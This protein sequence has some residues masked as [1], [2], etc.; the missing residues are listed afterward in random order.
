MDK[1]LIITKGR[2]IMEPYNMNLYSFQK[3]SSICEGLD[4][5]TSLLDRPQ[6][7]ELKEEAIEGLTTEICEF[8]NRIDQFVS[9]FKKYQLP[10]AKNS[11]ITQ[12]NNSALTLAHIFL[13][14][15]KNLND[16]LTLSIQKVQI[17]VQ[18]GEVK[19]MDYM[20]QKNWVIYDLSSTLKRNIN[21]LEMP[22]PT[23]I[24]S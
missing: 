21:Q 17:G 14:K 20:H 6:F 2:V 8:S 24:F 19:L 3:I 1:L 9:E 22:R 23:I 12:L 11:T 10:E 4:V 15:M 18:D 13:L 5:V 7:D 16:S